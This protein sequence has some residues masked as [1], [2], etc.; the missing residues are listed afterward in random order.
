MNFLSDL[1]MSGLGDPGKS[2]TVTK[3][4]GTNLAKDNNTVPVAVI[5][6]SSICITEKIAKTGSQPETPSSAGPKKMSFNM[7]RLPWEA[8]FQNVSN[9]S[10]SEDMNDMS[11]ISRFVASGVDEVQRRCSI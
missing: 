7:L 8:A 6:P 1:P 10:Q 2:A 5:S 4:N 3:D 9:A 11:D